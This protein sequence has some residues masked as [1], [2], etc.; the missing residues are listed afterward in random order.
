MDTKKKRRKKR[1]YAPVIAGVVIALIIITGGVIAFSK[2]SPTKETMPLSEYFVSTQENEVSVILNGQY[3]PNKEISNVEAV[4]AG[5]KIFISIEYLKEHIDD[6][7]VFDTVEGVLRY[8]TDSVVISSGLNKTQYTEGRETKDFDGDIV[9]ESNGEYYINLNFVKL[10][11]DLEYSFS[12]NPSRINI[13]TVDSTRE[14]ATLIKATAVRRFGGPKSKILKEAE[15]GDSIQVLEDYGKWSAIMTEDS[16]IG[17]VRNK[18]IS[19]ITTEEYQPT[20]PKREYR[21]ILLDKNI[22]LGW[23]QV[24]G[25]GGNSTLDELLSVAK[26]VNVISPTW[27]SISDNSGNIRDFSSADYVNKCHTKN[28]QVWGL[29]SN[30]EIEG[31]DTTSVLNR[32]SSRDNLVNNVIG[33]AIASNLD[34]INVDFEAVS[35]DAKDGYIEFIRE[36]SIKCKNNDLVLSVDNYKPEDFNLFYNRAEQAKYADYIIVMAYDEYHGAS[37]EAGSNASLPFVKT[38]VNDTLEYVPAEQLVLALPFYTRAWIKNADSLTNKAITMREI[39]GYMERNGGTKIWLP[40]EE[41]YYTTFDENGKTVQMWMEDEES[42]SR[43][44]SVY[45]ENKLAGVAFWRLG[46]EPSTI[47]DVISKYIE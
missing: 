15:K 22:V 20:I 30:F 32:T 37:T 10:F 23:H 7:Y 14:M 47:W 9:I 8:V 26:D 45:K 42:M 16:V 44:L 11:T 24:G 25:K 3:E 17:C 27:F 12:S 4:S 21:H 36:L 18:Y 43:K 2:Y 5:D 29:L 41:Q 39:P 19:N 13:R 1:N 35:I 6:G 34:G 46:A 28:I 33:A 38:A 40:E 31:I